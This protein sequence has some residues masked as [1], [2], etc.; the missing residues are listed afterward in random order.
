MYKIHISL[1][2][3]FGV[4]LSGCKINAQTS[5]KLHRQAD[6]AGCVTRLKYIIFIKRYAVN[7]LQ[8]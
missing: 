4:L 5:L 3:R 1:L 8:G 2:V 6:P 7:T